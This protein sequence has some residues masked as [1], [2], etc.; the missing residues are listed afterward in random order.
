[1]IDS[2]SE[3]I[4]NKNFPN[5]KRDCYKP[6]LDRLLWVDKRQD[7]LWRVQHNLERHVKWKKRE[8]SDILERQQVVRMENK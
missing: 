5:T 7:T 1:M 3:R 8:K 6:K 2:N 4:I